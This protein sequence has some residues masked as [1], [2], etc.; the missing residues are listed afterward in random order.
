MDTA[1]T[2]PIV[3]TEAAATKARALAERDGRPGAALRVRVTAGGCSGFSY[4]LTLEDAPADDDHVVDGPG[5]F[6]VLV[7]PASVPI[8]AGAGVFWL[9]ILIVLTL[10]DVLTRGW[11][12]VP[13]DW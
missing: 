9:A 13:D 3:V 5:G 7:D 12:P 8:V 1:T 6:R 10:G 4:E 2:P 11:L